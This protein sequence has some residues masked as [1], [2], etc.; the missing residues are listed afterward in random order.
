MRRAGGSR[1]ARLG[2]AALAVLLVVLAIAQI[3]LPRLA[4]SRI[5]SRI[6]RYGQVI[7]VSVSAFPAEKLL[8]GDADSVTAR[9]GHLSLSPAQAA[10]LLWESRGVARMTVSASSV[11][12]GKLAVEQA[13]LT[14]RGDSL[15]ARAQTTAPQAQAA[16]PGIGLR[17]LSSSGGR[18]EVRASGGLFGVQ[19]SVDAVA[20]ASEGKLLAHPLGFLLEGLQL[21]LFSERHVAVAG[22]GASLAG[23]QPLTYGLTVSA[24]L[25]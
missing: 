20:E 16:L 2:L 5:R 17:L 10:A 21:T 1:T 25:H 23:S 14:K 24:L 9:A 13:S 12:I 15:S 11:S 7:S 4:A 8:W 6:G 3:V 22:V 19:A 18:V